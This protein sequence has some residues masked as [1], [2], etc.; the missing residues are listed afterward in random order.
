MVYHGVMR[1]GDGLSVIRDERGQGAL[2]G[3]VQGGGGTGAGR[4][5]G[6]ANCATLVPYADLARFMVETTKEFVRFSVNMVK[7]SAARL[8]SPSSFSSGSPLHGRPRPPRPVTMSASG[9]VSSDGSRRVGTSSPP[10]VDRR[11]PPG[12]APVRSSGKRKIIA[13][14]VLLA[15]GTAG[16]VF[17]LQ[18]RRF[19]ET[20]DAQI[21]GNIT[22]LGS[23]V[24]GTVTAVKVQENQ[25][26]KAGEVLLEIDPT[27]LAVAVAQ[28]K[29][30]VAQAQA[31]LQAE[32]PTVSITETSNTAAVAGASSEMASARAGLS[33]SQSDVDQLAAAAGA[34]RG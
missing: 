20:D 24:I 3:P 30:S 33:G 6:S 32:D 15:V 16:L 22:N 11:E 27:D 29:A 14:L 28:A 23:R 8:K 18:G 17:Y 25:T 4:G 34:G 31:Q 12:S 1:S 7:P 2:L 5:C 13:L 10:V 21:D 19:Q 9:D 26:V